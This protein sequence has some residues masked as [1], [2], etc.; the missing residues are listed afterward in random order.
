MRSPTAAL[1]WEIWRKG[2]QLFWIA[3][4]ILLFGW[5]YN[6]ILPGDTSTV[7]AVHGRLALNCLLAVA[8]CVFVFAAFNYTEFSRQKEWTGFPYRLFALPVT[9]LRL[10]AVPIC[11]GLAVVELVY[12]GWLKLVFTHNDLE[13]PAWFAALLGSCM[14]FYQM[15]LW[16]LARLRMVRMIALGVGGT[17]GIGVAFLPFFAR[18]IP[19]R[20]LSEPVLIAFL[21]FSSAFA[22][23]IAWRS[24]VRQRGDG[25]YRRNR[26]RAFAEW[27]TDV[28]PRRRAA[29]R[30]ASSA[31]FWFEWRSSGMLLPVC[32]GALLIGV[33]TPMSWVERNDPDGTVWI[34]FWTLAAPMVLALP[35]GKGFAKPDFWTFNLALRP[36]VAVRPLSN[37]EMVVIKLKVAAWSAVMS[38]A[39]VLMFLAVWMPLGANLDAISMPRLGFWMAYDHAMY[40]QY[41]VAVLLLLSGMF[42]TWRFLVG[43][44]W[45]GLSGNRNIF[46]APFAIWGLAI[47]LEIV[48]VTVAS[49][50]DPEFRAWVRHD[51]NRLLSILEWIVVLAVVAKF[52]LAVR[53]WRNVSPKRTGI[54]LLAWVG[55]TL[56]LVALAILLWCHGLLD[57][58]L[59]AFCDIWPLDVVRLRSLLILIAL[60]II[61]FARLGLAPTMLATNRHR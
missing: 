17:T 32:V 8:S 23:A 59:M 30:D 28:M 38:W 1:T 56:C 55:G 13:K 49:N 33:I 7:A 34:L 11:L 20:W 26:L 41:I 15:I 36:F 31:H 9:S 48:S 25:G 4:G 45:A 61:P 40:P 18:E 21:I 58:E 47:L 3:G 6:L 12:C 57:M 60:W 43:G 16:T 35:I 29:F 39:F 50:Y 2:R 53:T 5:L 10:V 22:F 42:L 51:P 54:F 19:S 46:I 44:L 24:I 27:L 52:F 14:V 37:G